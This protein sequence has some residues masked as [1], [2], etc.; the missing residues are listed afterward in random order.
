M[1]VFASLSTLGDLDLHLQEYILLVHKILSVPVV[2]S[3]K[4]N[5]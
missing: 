5:L 3:F 2:L 1:L 4:F